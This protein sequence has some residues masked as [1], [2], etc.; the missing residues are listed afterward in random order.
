M[1]MR[2]NN[3]MKTILK[4]AVLIFTILP[5]AAV[6]AYGQQQINMAAG[7]ATATMPDGSVVQMWGYSCG[8]V[9]TGSTATCASLNPTVGGGGWSPVVIT[10]PTGQA[11]T[12][13]LTNNLF[14]A[15]GCHDCEHCS[16]IADDRRTGG[17]RSWSFGP[18]Y[19]HTEPRPLAGAS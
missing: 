10:V 2:V 16:H 1:N 15:N 3:M 4:A 6:A 17:W 12:I 9:V 18:A 8:A 19:H 11:L 14:Y 13:N 7:P 5:F